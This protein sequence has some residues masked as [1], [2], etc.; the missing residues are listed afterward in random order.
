MLAQTCLLRLAEK[1]SDTMPEN[2][3]KS[4]VANFIS[5]MTEISP[6]ASEFVNSQNS[7]DEES[8]SLPPPKPHYFFRSP[9][10]SDLNEAPHMTRSNSTPNLVGSLGDEEAENAPDQPKSWRRASTMPNLYCN[11]ALHN[12]SMGLGHLSDNRKVLLPDSKHVDRSSEFDDLLHG[13]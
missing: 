2:V 9:S 8:E 12:R 3:I 5:E 7:D 11:R 1:K 13:L 10:A 6:H 4:R